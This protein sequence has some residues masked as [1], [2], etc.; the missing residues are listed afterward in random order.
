MSAGRISVRGAHGLRVALSTPA[1]GRGGPLTPVRGFAVPSLKNNRVTFSSPGVDEW[2]A[3]G[4]AGVEQGLVIANR[5]VGPGPLE[6]S[7]TLSGNAAGR[8]QAGGQRVR[9]GSRAEGLRYG[10]LVVVDAKGARIQA[11][12]SLSGHRLTISIEDA[13]AVYPLRV[14]PEFDAVV[15]GG[16]CLVLCSN[17]NGTS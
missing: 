9:F 17:G 4:S 15:A 14:D 8:V 10:K 11:S 1:I 7:Q 12:M 13:D 5:S 16:L 3:H 6:I 2:Y